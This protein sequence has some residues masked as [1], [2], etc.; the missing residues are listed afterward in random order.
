MAYFIVNGESMGDHVNMFGPYLTLKDAEAALSQWENLTS[1]IE[2]DGDDY[3]HIVKSR[4]P[5][6]F[7][8]HM[9]ALRS[10]RAG[11]QRL[12]EEQENLEAEAEDEGVLSDEEFVSLI[13]TVHSQNQNQVEASMDEV[14]EM[15]KEVFRSRQEGQRPLDQQQEENGIDDDNN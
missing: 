7:A 8:K 11:E 2:A 5:E 13:D 1:A 15:M 10:E 4:S 6:D 3:F 9:S 12:S 14:F